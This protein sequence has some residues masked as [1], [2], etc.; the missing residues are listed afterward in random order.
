M[1]GFGKEGGREG[2]E[3]GWEGEGLGRKGAGKEGAGKEGGQERGGGGTDGWLVGW[4]RHVT[5][6]S[7][8]L[9]QRFSYRQQLQL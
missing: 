1:R 7:H 3:G 4:E 8:T 9:G 6:A 5:T 2:G